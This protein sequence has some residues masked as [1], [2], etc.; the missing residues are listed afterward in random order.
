MRMIG[1]WELYGLDKADLH[2]ELA[3]A[4]GEAAWRLCE[5]MLANQYPS[6]WS[7]A[8]VL[9]SLSHHAVELFLKYALAR[10]SNTVPGNHYI[11]E[12]YDQYLNVYSE[13]AFSFDPKF[14]TEF[15]G[16][17]P[18]SVSSALAKEEQHKNKIDQMFRYHTDRSGSP[19]EGAHGFLPE[20][21]C[22]DMQVFLNRMKEIRSEIEKR[23]APQ[24]TAA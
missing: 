13:E 19:W 17:T 4:Y 21:F 18:E 2:Y 23:L 11:R 6:T 7:H 15:L 20:E 8:K 22:K 10:S 9:L 3:E 12:L 14:I 24:N 1:N 5:G 16:G